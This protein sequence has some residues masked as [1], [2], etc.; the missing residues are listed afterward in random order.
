MAREYNINY[1]FVSNPTKF[2]KKKTV[3]TWPTIRP[4]SHF[5]TA[6]PALNAF[7]LINWEEK[8]V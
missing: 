4:S 6:K 8:S 3:F 7:P 5:S 2:Q 1:F